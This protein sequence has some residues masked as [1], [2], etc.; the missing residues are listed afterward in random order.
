MSFVS[1]LLKILGVGALILFLL[2]AYVAICDP[3]SVDT[4]EGRRDSPVP[5]PEA[6]SIIE[7]KIQALKTA[8]ARNEAEYKRLSEDVRT[9]K[10]N[11]ELFDARLDLVSA[12]LD[13][14][15]GELERALKT[16]DA[17]YEKHWSTANGC[18][19]ACTRLKEEA[20]E[21]LKSMMAR[22]TELEKKCAEHEAYRREAEEHFKK[23][24]MEQAELLRKIEHDKKELE[25]TV[26]AQARTELKGVLDAF[27]TAG[28][29]T[30]PPPRGASQATALEDRS[31]TSSQAAAPVTA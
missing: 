17:T 16:I 1:G 11:A 27:L 9:L 22:N 4:A 31:E 18:S 12:E 29:A 6:V 5:T 28:F 21:E 20:V 30:A 13:F 25:K 19:E 15:R 23:M 24:R 3:L 8:L 10:R 14:V 7:R 26:R 2:V